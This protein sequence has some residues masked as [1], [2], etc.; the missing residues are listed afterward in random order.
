MGRLGPAH[1]LEQHGSWITV[2]SDLLRKKY[3]PVLSQKSKECLVKGI[4][5]FFIFL[6]I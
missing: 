3:N 2:E 4:L 5:Y 1:G 6:I